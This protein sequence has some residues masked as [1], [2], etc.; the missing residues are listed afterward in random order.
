MS[1]LPKDTIVSVWVNCSDTRRVLNKGHQIIH[2][3]A[4]YFY[5][6][7]GLGGWISQEGGGDNWLNPFKTW[8]RIYS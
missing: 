5:L 1:S 2:A 7:V 8:A 6:D 4:N 3:A